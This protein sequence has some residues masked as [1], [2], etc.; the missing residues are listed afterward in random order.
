VP[1]S[2]DTGDGPTDIVEEGNPVGGIQVA[3]GQEIIC[4]GRDCGTS[5]AYAKIGCLISADVSRLA[6]LAPGRPLRFTEVTVAQA[7]HIR[8]EY[9]AV[10]ASISDARA[11]PGNEPPTTTQPAASQIGATG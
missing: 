7:R 6:Q 2:R 11:G 8:A 10:I 3:G 9:E 5:G 4:L 1:R